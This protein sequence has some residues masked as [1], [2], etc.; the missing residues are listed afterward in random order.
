[1]ADAMGSDPMALA[2]SGIT[3]AGVKY[4]FIKGDAE[5]VIGKKGQSGVV[6]HKC[7]TCMLVNVHNESIQTAACNAAVATLSTYLRENQI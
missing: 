1:M 4:M 2:G 6:I 3:I 5:E 7:K